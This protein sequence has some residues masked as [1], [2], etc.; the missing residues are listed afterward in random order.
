M[1][2]VGNMVGMIQN[3]RNSLIITVGSVNHAK[4]LLSTWYKDGRFCTSL[5]Y[6]WLR[7]KHDN[8]PCESGSL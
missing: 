8:K 6:D 3:L 1:F 5:A 4:Q 7:I 2:G